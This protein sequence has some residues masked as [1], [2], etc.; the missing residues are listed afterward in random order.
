MRFRPKG[1]GNKIVRYWLI[2][3]ALLS[4]KRPLHYL[5]CRVK[6]N[7]TLVIDIKVLIYNLQITFNL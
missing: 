1:L 5:I 7:K 3:R 4:I 2:P 6:L